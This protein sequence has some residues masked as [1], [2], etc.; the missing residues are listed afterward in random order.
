M[1]TSCDGLWS[2]KADPGQ[3]EQIISNLVVNSR[4]AMPDGGK[5]T[6]ETLNVTLDE[7]YVKYHANIS[8]GEYIMLSVSD[9]GTGMDEETKSKIFEP[10]FTTKEKG[11]GT[12]LGLSTCYGI[13]KQSGG[14][15]WM[16]S[17]PNQ[18]TTFKI[19][20]PRF[21]GE[22]DIQESYEDF[23]DA[24]GGNETILIVEDEPMVRKIAVQILSG[25]FHKL[26]YVFS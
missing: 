17:E 26:C 2:V 13:V 14:H 24:P 18:G 3:I 6:I 12:G 5:I 1:T 9:T 22:P 11:K 8:P 15:I 23:G 7:E 21:E 16:Y 25:L 4:D 19:Y 10:F 20:M